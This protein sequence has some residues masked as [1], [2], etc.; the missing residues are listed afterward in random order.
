MDPSGPLP[1]LIERLADGRLRIN[2][3]WQW[4]SKPGAGTSILEEEIPHHR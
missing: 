3:T 1:D 2:E 4:E